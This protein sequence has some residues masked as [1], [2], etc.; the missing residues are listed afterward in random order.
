[1]ELAALVQAATAAK[2]WFQSL[3][4][5]NREER[6]R[7]TTALRAL[8]TALNETQIYVGRLAR[9]AYGGGPRAER[10]I[11]TEE[12][13]SRLW[14]EAS[15]QLRDFNLDLAGRCLIKGDYWTNPDAWPEE[16][17]KAARIELSRVFR[18]ARELL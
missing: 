10:N 2:E 16:E 15:I 6:E 7:Y 12:K 14:T 11:E 5:R 18:E 4:T 17:V 9:P 13:L 8:Y 3:R 1:M